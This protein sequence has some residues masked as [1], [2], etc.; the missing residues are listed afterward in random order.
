MKNL[1]WKRFSSFTYLNISQFLVT[2]ND[3]IF[4]L[5]VAYSLIDLQGT[6]MA[7]TIL[8]IS[9][10]LFVLP[11]LLFTMPA[12]DL[13]DRFS[14]KKII[15]WMMVAEVVAMIYGLFAIHA[16]DV[17]GAYLALFFVALQAAIFNP[18]K[19]AIIPEVVTKEK[20]SKINGILTLF[21]Y[22]AII[23]G[24]FFAS[25]ITQITNRN[26]ILVVCI[27]ILLAIFG[28]YTSLQIEDTPRQNP[29][30]KVNPFFFLEII[31]SLKISR[32]YPHL[33][34]A[35][36]G[37]A[38][39]LFTATYTQLN[40]IPFG[41]QSLKITDVQTGYVFLAAAF[42]MGAG[43]IAVAYLSGKHVELGFA[44]VGGIGTALSY[45]LLFIFSSDIFAA[46]ILIFSLGFHGGLY[47]V[48]LDAH[49]QVASPEKE[50][51]EIVAASAFLGFV[52]VLFA[53]G[54]IELFGNVLGLTAAEGFLIIGGTSLIVALI[55]TVL[56]PDYFMR[57]ISVLL[58]RL[59]FTI[60]TS[61]DLEKSLKEPGIIV[62]KDFSK[63]HIMSLIQVYPRI[64]FIKLLSQK[65]SSLKMTFLNLF[66]IIPVYPHDET[67]HKHLAKT[68]DHKNSV[69]LFL[70]DNFKHTPELIEE[71]LKNHAYPIIPFR[72]EKQSQSKD[73]NL[74]FNFFR[75]FSFSIHIFLGKFLSYP[76]DLENIEKELNTLDQKPLPYL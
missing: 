3:S 64:R 51:G 72:V 2:L 16:K 10:A 63:I 59:F 42:G 21:T 27:C 7:N 69:A 71:I 20:L 19:Y 58:S 25:F 74:F 55:V 6:E 60:T 46:V 11:F 76:T 70:N 32:K 66:H 61:G 23:L 4:R 67:C 14:K 33:L 13:A 1:L 56:L 5:L 37:S 50:R 73:N 47:I 26:Y 29:K 17:V 12:G 41:I 43:A 35:V 53:A 31:H 30:K 48:P 34:L 15:V 68:L 44:I 36:L 40:T 38:Y 52:G 75:V 57:L 28:L 62:C 39:F 54:A 65:P 22:L 45:I 9:G 49:I 8:A 18:A 24:T